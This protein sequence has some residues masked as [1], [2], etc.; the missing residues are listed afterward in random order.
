[1][2]TVWDRVSYRMARHLPGTSIWR[3]GFG[4]IVSF[5]FDDAPP[6][7]ATTGADILE[8]FGYRGTFYLSGGWLGGQGDVQEIMSAEQGRALHRRGHE[9]GCH[10][11][12]H[13]DMSRTAWSTAA[14]DLERNRAALTEICGEPPRHFAYPFGRTSYGLKT[15]IQ[16]QYQSCRGVTPGLN[17]GRIHL[18]LLNSVPLYEANPEA[19]TQDWLEQNA[20]KAA[21]LIFYTHDV[22]ED[23]T[24]YGVTP[25]GF[26]AALRATVASGARV[27][28]VGD[29]VSLLRSDPRPAVV[30]QV[31]AA[32]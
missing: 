3:R 18:G 24:A 14:R 19:T 4:P 25:S 17:F 29:A 5:T 31:S 28:T 27:M 16:S 2:P 23:P 20:A 30:P 7:A 21:W 6:S 32:E 8:R 9:I 12:Q 13:L 22:R 11:Y 1:M 26:E 10:S 15:R